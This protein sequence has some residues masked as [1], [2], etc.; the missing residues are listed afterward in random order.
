MCPSSLPKM[1]TVPQKR[2]GGLAL[3]PYQGADVEAES[4]PF[5]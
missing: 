2:P 1:L 3:P 5:P 4:F